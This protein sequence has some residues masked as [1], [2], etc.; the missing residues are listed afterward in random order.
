ML[1]SFCPVG[2]LSFDGLSV[3]FQVLMP[4]DSGSNPEA[5]NIYFSWWI[6]NN[7]HYTIVTL[8]KATRPAQVREKIEILVL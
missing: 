4:E 5:G 3:V 6:L 8:W 7:L 1:L 2:W